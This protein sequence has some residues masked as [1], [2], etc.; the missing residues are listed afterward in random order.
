VTTN[1]VTTRSGGF[2]NPE[3]AWIYNTQDSGGLPTRGTLLEG[4]LG[5]S[6]RNIPFPYLQNHFSTFHPVH[7]Q[8]SLFLASDEESSFGKNV[9]FYD[10]FT[11]G[12]ARQLEA[13]RYQEFRANTLVSAG[14]GAF[15]HV[16]KVRRWSLNPSFAAWYEAAR[17]DL[18]SQGWQTHQSTSLGAFVPSPIGVVGLTLSFAENGNA[19]FRFLLGGF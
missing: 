14:G 6:F 2:A 16:F 13:Y 4:S 17:L 11:Y 12:G 8:I 3:T 9:S 19:R 5:Y 18:G 7:N 15:F 1:G 10:Q